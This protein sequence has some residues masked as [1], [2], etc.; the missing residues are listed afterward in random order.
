VQPELEPGDHPEVAAPA[1]QPPEQLGVLV[2]GRPHHLAVRGHQLEGLDVVAGE[3]VL[4][5]HPPHPA[6]EREAADAG[7][8]DVAGG[9]GQPVPLGLGVERAEQRPALHRRA[10][11]GRVDA[12]R[13]HRGEVDHQAVVGDPEADHA[14]PAAPHADLQVQVAGGAHGRDHVADAGA[15][16]DHPRAVVDHGVPHRQAPS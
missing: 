16:H 13:G 5:G 12:D 1:A 2:P 9:G 3:A 10:P 11:A 15:A 4:A 8:G 7:V 14:V 6:A